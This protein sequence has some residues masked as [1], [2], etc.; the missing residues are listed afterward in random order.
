MI[1]GWSINPRSTRVLSITGARP[2][3]LARCRRDDLDPKSGELAIPRSAKGRPGLRKHTAT[4]TSAIPITLAAE[5]MAQ[6]EQGSGL[7]FH[8]RRNAQE[9]DRLRTLDNALLRSGAIG[10]AWQ[11]VGRTGWS[12]NLWAR[13][14][15]EA[16]KRAGLPPG[17]TI[18]T[19][20]HTLCRRD[21]PW[22][23]EPARDRCAAGY[24]RSDA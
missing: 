18:Y 11:D 23:V 17:V 22:R 12:K 8:T 14:V 1:R 6:A 16:V 5:V 21:D 9:L 19:L 10:R 2:G 13:P 7:L 4:I 15:R 24:V 20:R 3:S